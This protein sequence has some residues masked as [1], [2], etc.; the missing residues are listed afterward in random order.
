[1][2]YYAPDAVYDMSRMGM[3]VFEGRDA[4]R[5]FLD[6]WEV[7][8]E[9]YRDDIQ[10][11][12]DLGHGVVFLAAGMSARLAGSP[13]RARVQARYG[14][15]FVWGDGQVKRATPY[16]DVDEAR[17]AAERLARERG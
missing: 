8:Y 1:M 15:V 4:I 14:Y 17:A 13:T 6:D 2:A 11:I 3:G 9:D 5:A 10:E 7:R 16:L 12:A